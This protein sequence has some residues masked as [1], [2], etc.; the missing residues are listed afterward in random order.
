MLAPTGRGGGFRLLSA[1]QGTAETNFRQILLLGFEFGYAAISDERLLV[2][3]DLG[4]FSGAW[5]DATV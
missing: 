5:D 3:R 1:A 2:G 4:I